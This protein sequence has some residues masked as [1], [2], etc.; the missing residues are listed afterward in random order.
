[1]PKKILVVDD[2]LEIC[3]LMSEY[4]TDLGYEVVTTA[5]GKAALK[6]ASK[7][8]FDLIFLDIYLPDEDGVVIYEKIRQMPIH[9]KTPVIFLTALASGTRFP[10]LGSKHEQYSIISKPV[11]LQKIEEEVKGLIG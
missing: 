8:Q 6:E 9:A 7:S 1:M 10:L 5:T 4:L 3:E 2:E 11:N